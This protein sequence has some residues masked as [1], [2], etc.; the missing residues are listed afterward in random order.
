MSEIRGGIS[1]IKSALA[2]VISEIDFIT[3][4]KEQQEYVLSEFLSGKDVFG[5]LP[6]GFGKSLIY[7][8]APLILKKMFPAR[9]PIFIIISPL[10]A[11][12]E[13]QIREASKLGIKAKMIGVHPD[14]DII[15]GRCQLVFGSP[16]AWLQNET[17]TKMLANEVY[18]HLEGIVHDE[19]HVAY[20]W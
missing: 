17:W 19:V 5:V 8:L 3:E 13:D 15:Q 20:K 1:E 16:E 14:R 2:D 4:V 10:N 18:L 7:Q 6:T 9:N 12:T 11:L